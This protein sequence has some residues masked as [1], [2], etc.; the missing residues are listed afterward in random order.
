M[1]MYIGFCLWFNGTVRGFESV[2][3]GIHH[4]KAHLSSLLSL[5]VV[6]DW[7]ALLPR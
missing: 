6:P 7:S 1:N 5:V 4:S 2:M 3:L